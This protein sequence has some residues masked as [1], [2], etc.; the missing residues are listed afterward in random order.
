MRYSA[1][2]FF[3]FLL[4]VTIGCK[5]PYNPPVIAN[6][7]NYLVVEGTIL[8]GADSTIIKLSRT[9]SLSNGTPPK[10]VSQATLTVESNANSTFPLTEIKPGS[11]ASPGLNLDNTKQYRLRIVT[12]DNQ[13]YLS[14]FVPLQVTPPIDSIGFS[15]LNNGIELYV[16]SHDPNNNTR[17]YRWDYAETWEFHAKFFSSDITDGKQL[18]PRNPDQYVYYCF[19]GDV[20][21]TILLGSSAKLTQDVIYQSP[22]GFIPSTSE[23]IETEY[24]ILLHQYALTN[25]A[26]TFWTNLKKNTEQLGSIF[27]AEPS[28]INGNIHNTGNPKEPVF[29]YISASTVQSKR[30]FIYNT[31]LP[32]EWV[33]NYPYDCEVD[34]LLIKQPISMVNQVQEYLIPLG[35]SELAIS[36]IYVQNSI[37]GYTAAGRTCA[38]CS[39]R[40]VVQP[41]SFWQ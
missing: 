37:V 12:S 19:A 7:P 15:V 9:V 13:V 6:V 11:Y 28:Q 39:I 27:D 33:P 29:G 31:Q 35:S 3:C 41:P 20:S 18:L 26:F 14:D 36:P 30:V 10:P 23:K 16:N 40:G 25:E 17:Y 1:I 4:L 8:S 5:K 32:R 22:L 24:S 38:D 21:S 34:S 2:Y